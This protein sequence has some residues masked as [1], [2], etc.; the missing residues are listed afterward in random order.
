MIRKKST[1]AGTK[2]RWRQMWRIQPVRA[3]EK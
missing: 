3:K 1:P 2:K